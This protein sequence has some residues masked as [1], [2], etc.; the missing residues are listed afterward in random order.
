V[1]PEFP[2]ECVA[3]VQVALFGV[4]RL[5]ICTALCLE[6]AGYNVLGVDVNHRYVSCKAR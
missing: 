5:G 1:K 4:G 3:C 6:K 2:A